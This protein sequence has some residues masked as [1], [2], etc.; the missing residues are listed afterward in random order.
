MRNILI[1]LCLLI[2]TAVTAQDNEY[3]YEEVI[4]GERAVD[5]M[6][7]F[8][9]GLPGLSIYISDNLKYP[10]EALKNHIEGKVLCSF[11]IDKDGSITDISIVRSSG[12][13]S[14]DNEAIRMLNAMP[15]WIPGKQDGKTVRVRYLLPVNF[16]IPTD[17][18]AAD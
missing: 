3:E 8:P 13:D 6:P 11:I 18:P 9:Y 4:I 16:K 7:K 17:I 12:Y 14:L 15:K 10:N 1:A 2:A 5:I